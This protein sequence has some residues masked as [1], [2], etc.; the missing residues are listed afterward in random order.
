MTLL[1][2]HTAKKKQFISCTGFYIR[3]INRWEYYSTLR[4]ILK[5]FHNYRHFLWI[6]RTREKKNTNTSIT[7]ENSIQTS[8][9]KKCQWL[10]WHAHTHKCSLQICDQAHVRACVRVS[11]V[12]HCIWSYL[13][14]LTHTQCYTFLYKISVSTNIVTH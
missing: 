7:N 13:D 3:P 8:M 4:L 12:A 6:K 10:K 2:D 14:E 1:C 9:K 11:S 5:K